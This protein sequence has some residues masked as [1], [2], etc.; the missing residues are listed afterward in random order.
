[1]PEPLV[2]LKNR[3]H[4]SRTVRRQ[5]LL[6]YCARKPPHPPHRLPCGNRRNG[7]QLQQLACT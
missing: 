2:Q 6:P 5:G 7:W 1:M 3:L 4:L